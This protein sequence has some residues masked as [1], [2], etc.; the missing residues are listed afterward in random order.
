MN[1]NRREL[2]NTALLLGL[3]ACSSPRVE[4]TPTPPK[5]STK[6]E[7]KATPTITSKTEYSYKD[8][9]PLPT[10]KEVTDL[11]AALPNPYRLFLQRYVNP[12]LEDSFPG[13]VQLGGVNIR[14]ERLSFGYEEIE[15][16]GGHTNIRLRELSAVEITAR[17][18]YS[19]MLPYN[20]EGGLTLKVEST[21]VVGNFVDEGIDPGIMLNLPVKNKIKTI[22]EIQRVKIARE[23]TLLKELLTLAFDLCYIE[24]MI[25][26]MKKSQL[27]LTLLIN[28][29]QMEMVVQG[30]IDADKNKGR[31]AGIGDTA[32]L[33]MLVKTRVLKAIEITTE[34]QKLIY[35]ANFGNDPQSLVKNSAKFLLENKA[36]LNGITG[37]THNFDKLP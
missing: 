27:P 19:F 9:L 10:K 35:S 33:L 29:R 17:T 15:S 24:E 30:F 20:M 34:Q 6:V 31:M 11:M 1:L 14:A 37:V 8:Y 13:V 32:P 23:E 3:T 22:Q 5:A 16:L 21:L 12:L 26:L 2:L 4:S 36:A 25:T 7:P 28:G 18:P